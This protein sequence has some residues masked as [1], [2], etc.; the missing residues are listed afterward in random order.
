MITIK[1]NGIIFT[2]EDGGDTLHS[3]LLKH[4]VLVSAP[5]GGKGKCG[6]CRV[7]IVSG[8][9]NGDVPDASSTVRACKAVAVGDITIETLE[10]WAE[11]SEGGGEKLN[12][13][14]F[15]VA[16]DVGTTT[17]VA[18]LVDLT[19]GK[20]VEIISGLNTQ[21]ILG[22]DVISRIT[23]AG[24]GKTDILCRLIINQTN[25]MI[26]RFKEKYAIEEIE[27]LTV[28]ANTTMLH[29]F[30]GVSPV[31]I[32]VLPF[33]PVFTQAERY[34]GSKLG[35]NVRQAVLMPSISGFLGADIVSCIAAKSIDK[36]EKNTLVI[37][38]GTNGEM[39][40]CTNGK[41]YCCS[42]AT[43]PALEGAEISC[44]KG[45]VSG[46][47]DHVYYSD[48][49]VSYSSIGGAVADGICGSGLIDAVSVML[50]CGALEE[51]GVVESDFVIAPGVYINQRDIRQFQLAKSAIISGI[52]LLSKAGGIT[53]QQIE[54]VYI[55]GGLGFYLN[56]QSAIRV[57]MFPSCFS[58]KTEVSG[59]LSLEGAKMCLL[60]DAELER[61]SNISTNCTLIELASDPEFMEEFSENMFF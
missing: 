13:N 17:L 22:A 1:H 52:K 59:N 61:F 53:A 11:I 7:K 54:K 24:N 12:G 16:L 44:G 30:A 43:G 25:R 31:S 48:G 18:A 21:G 41:I 47:V 29:L 40:L 6:K 58:G 56:T 55:A 9:V 8:A 33:K 20:T 15:G 35:L 39:A 27:K 45:G 26:L 51:S 19:S 46:A 57:G 34:S 5:C 49:K 28:S 14:R 2:V 42:T 10:Q 37:D 38:V 36:A 23:A 50:R 60:D 32:G 4:G 3:E